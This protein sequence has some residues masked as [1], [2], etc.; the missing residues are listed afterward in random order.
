[1]IDEAFVIEPTLKRRKETA[2]I[3]VEQFVW[4][5][6]DPM[7]PRANPLCGI[8]WHH[9]S[10]PGRLPALEESFGRLQQTRGELFAS[11]Q[12]RVLPLCARPFSETVHMGL[13]REHGG[14]C[15]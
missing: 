2:F 8:R 13:S 11:D 10:W 7:P 4:D 14:N 1:M 5:F 6:H 12:G 3:W 9:A 15:G